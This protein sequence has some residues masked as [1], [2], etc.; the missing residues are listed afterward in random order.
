M[1]EEQDQNLHLSFDEFLYLINQESWLLPPE[2]R[3]FTVTA[4]PSIRI[5]KQIFIFHQIWFSLK[6]HFL[7][8]C[9]GI[10][11]RPDNQRD[12]CLYLTWRCKKM[13]SSVV[14]IVGKVCQHQ[15]FKAISE[16]KLHVYFHWKTVCR[17]PQ[18][19]L[20]KYTWKCYNLYIWKSGIIPFFKKILF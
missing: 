9:L 5:H 13:W 17:H 2:K 7:T 6:L 8:L 18:N 11:L 16:R 12:L 1:K 4:V 19:N 10:Y 15:V 20:I 3:Q 14:D